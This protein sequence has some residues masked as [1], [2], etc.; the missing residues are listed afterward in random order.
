MKCGILYAEVMHGIAG[1]GT[2]MEQEKKQSADETEKKRIF[3]KSTWDIRPYLAMGLTAI[4]VVI[5]CIAIFFLVYRFQGLS[6]EIGKVIRSLQSILIGFV[7]AYLLNPIMKAFERLFNKHMYKGKEK[8]VQQKRKIRAISVACAMAVFFAIIA[9]LISLIVPEL[10]KSIEELVMTMNDKVQSLTDWIDRILKQDSPL[11]GRLDT[12]VADASKYLE[13]W[14]QENVLKQSDW[15]ASVTTGVYNVI[16]TIFN[17]IIGFIISVYVLMTKETFIGQLKKIIYAVFRPKWGNVVMEVVRK[18][19]DVFGGFFIG[20]IIDSLIIG[21]ICFVALYILRMPYVVLVSVVVGVTNVIPFFGPYIGA[22]PSVVL[23]FLVDPIKGLYFII[24][25]IIL[26]QVD[27]NII[28]PKILGDTTGLSPFWVIFAILLFGGSFGVLGMLFGVP[29]FAVIYYVVKRIVEHILSARKLPRETV[30]YI[31]LQS[32]DVKTNK[33]K[34][35]D[36]EQEK[37]I[38]QEK[39]EKNKK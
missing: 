25:I 5:V 10:V 37:V 7:L 21:G 38:R 9:V 17:V 18:A 14:L 35:L 19:D 15:I 6:D 33:T 23:I 29:I 22:I 13:K 30:D 11:A 24:F 36:E 34:M 8:T 20:K 31:H 1:K 2:V 16:R 39:Q 4:L 28:G 26:Q 3:S 32:V 12:L 27:G